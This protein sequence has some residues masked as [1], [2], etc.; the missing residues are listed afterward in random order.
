[1]SISVSH[2]LAGILAAVTSL[3]ACVPAGRQPMRP[4][5]P[6]LT[7]TTVAPAPRPSAPTRPSTRP[8]PAADLL[9]AVQALGAS[10]K[11]QVG[12]TVRDID[13]GWVVAWDGDTR[14]PQQSVSKLW[15]AIAVMDAVDRGQIS[16]SDRV[17]LTRA[18]LTLFH[19]PI[20]ALIGADGYTT[21]IDELLRGAMTRSDNT[22][23]DVLLW[24]IGGPAAINR[25]LDAKGV[26]GVTFGPGERVLQAKTAGL[27]W[28]PEWA[29][30][31][32]FLQA[33]AAMTYEARAKA[34]NRYLAAPYDGASANGVTLG[35]SLLAQGKLLSARSTASLLTL[36]RSSKTGPLRL[37]SGLRP[38]W[39]L[40]HKTGT[41]Q[42]LGSLSTGYNDIGLLVAPNGHRYAVAVMI[43]STR[44][45]IPVRMRLMGDV[46]RAVVASAGN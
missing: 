34:L 46:T 43:A 19:Q 37:K 3:G 26:E 22:C 31:W 44:E 21:T 2:R 28:R 18:D 24:R 6:P 30:G 35:L 16:L 14:R 33:R 1:M 17:T 32:G 10:F 27:E 45:P 29:G 42:D 25:M 39:S 13:E 38:G 36:M 9:N 7:V 15:V 4:A 40:A 41:G 12:I 11:G 8:Q 23:N 20:R 5:P